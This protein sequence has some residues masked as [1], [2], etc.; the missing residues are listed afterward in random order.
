[1][2]P[3]RETLQRA[4]QLQHT[5]YKST[6]THTPAPRA[7]TQLMMQIAAWGTLAPSAQLHALRQR[8]ASRSAATMPC[9]WHTTPPCCWRNHATTQCTHLQKSVGSIV[10]CRPSA[11]SSSS[12]VA[13]KHCLHHCPLLSKQLATTQSKI[14]NMPP[15][16][17]ASTPTVLF[18]T[19]LCLWLQPPPPT[20]QL[21]KQQLH[22]P[23]L[24]RLPSPQACKDAC[25]CGV[26]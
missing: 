18:C 23:P 10:T 3:V 4:F 25:F 7:T 24:Q 12:L 20:Q 5:P 14:V 2:L 21:Q 26:C 22:T 8:A 13:H 15:K 11:K 6:H 1:M 9:W 19:L 17:T 16:P